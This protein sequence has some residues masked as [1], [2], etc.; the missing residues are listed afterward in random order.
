MNTI[1]KWAFVI[2]LAVGGFFS[3]SP[4]TQAAAK[5]YEYTFEKDTGDNIQ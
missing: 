4:N 5:P 3:L 2:L 1:W